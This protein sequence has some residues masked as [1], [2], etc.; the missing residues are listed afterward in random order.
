MIDYV[1]QLVEEAN[2]EPILDGKTA[3]HLLEDLPLLVVTCVER[4]Q[5]PR[6]PKMGRPNLFSLS[7]LEKWQQQSFL[8]GEINGQTV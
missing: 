7:D 8:N 5:I 4:K 2:C 1:H 6:F 3:A